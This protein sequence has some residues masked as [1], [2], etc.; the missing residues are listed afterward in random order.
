MRGLGAIPHGGLLDRIA[1]RHLPS[2]RVC[3]EQAGRPGA[4]LAQ[5]RQGAFPAAANVDLHPAWAMLRWCECHSLIA[6]AEGPGG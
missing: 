6:P 3:Q 4:L 2:P 1:A 5:R